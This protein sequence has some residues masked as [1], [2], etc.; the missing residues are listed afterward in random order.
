MKI[1]FYLERDGRTVLVMEGDS[2]R[3]FV[4]YEGLMVNIGNEP[5]VVSRVIVDYDRELILI[6][7]I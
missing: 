4:P 3:T 1:R 2:N 6:S 7:M 5:M